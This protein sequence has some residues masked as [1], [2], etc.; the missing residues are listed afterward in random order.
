MD[1]HYPY[2]TEFH[3][4]H[5]PGP[6]AI[7]HDPQLYAHD[8]ANPLSTAMPN[9]M[10]AFSY[11]H[12]AAGKG[13]HL[14]AFNSRYPLPP[15]AATHQFEYWHPHHAHFDGSVR[16]DS[17]R[18]DSQS[19]G[20]LS[21]YSYDDAVSSTSG[22]E[23]SPSPPAYHEPIPLAPYEL[24]PQSAVSEAAAPSVLHQGSPMFV[25]YQHQHPIEYA[26]TSSSISATSPKK[27]RTKSTART[28][29]TRKQPA[30]PSNRVQKQRN[31]KLP[32]KTPAGPKARSSPETT[33]KQSTKKS[34]DRRFECSFSRYGCTSTFPSKNEWKRHVSSQHI[35]PGFYRC[36]TGRCSLNNREASNKNSDC[37]S[38]SSSS[39]DNNNH[40][41][42]QPALLVNDFNRKD[43][44]IQHQ[45]RMHAPWV[46]SKSQRSGSKASGVSEE[47]KMAFEA[48]LEDVYRRCWKQLRR[49]PTRSRCGFCGQEFHGV[50][51]WKEGMEHVARHFEKGDQGPEEEDVPLREWAAEE[52]IIR[53]EKGAWRLTTL[54]RK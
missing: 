36:D 33:A 9:P 25:V 39:L 1:G 54:C 12:D 11:G 23:S 38:P 8:D 34:T 17:P 5:G 15:V 37:P 32:K 45:R 24:E 50:N 3:A 2:P 52:G 35:Q 31:S 40:Q 20:C 41:Q 49:P 29:T 21:A 43:L 4:Y 27:E 19:S 7:D 46:T 47:E 16:S 22:F 44:F 28:T 30:Q 10:V 48:S 42:S 13:P 14:P 26:S 18:S 51:A 6:L 53:L